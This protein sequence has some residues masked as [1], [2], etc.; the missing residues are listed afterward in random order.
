M[1]YRYLGRT[2]IKVSELG[3][4]C[5]TFEPGMVDEAA[6][7]NIMDRYV[8]AGG[9]FLD[10]ADNYRGVEAV[11]G[12]WAAQKGIR[13]QLVLASKVRY[14]SG[15]K[16]VNDIGLTRKHIYDAIDRTLRNLQTDYIDLYQMH[17]WDP[18]TPI[19]ESLRAFDDLIRA[20]KIRYIG[21]S[22]FT[23]WHI[24][25][26]ISESEK[27]HWSSIVSCQSQYS[28]LSRTAEWE[29]IPVCLEHGI[30]VNAW[31]PLGAGWLT[32]KYQRNE[33]PPAGSR[34]SRIAKNREDWERIIKL[35]ISTQ[36]PHPSRVKNEKEYR[37]ILQE[38]E[39]EHR[40]RIIDAVG[41][42]A[43]AKGKT[44]AQ[45][46][47]A[48]LLARPGLC[49][50]I[51]GSSSVKQLEENLGACQCCL[52]QE[53][54]QWLDQVSDPGRPYPHDFYEKYSL[55]APWR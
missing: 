53:E 30:S 9:N 47:L 44:P 11:V 34:M 12:R 31:S 5:M 17:C 48:W 3:L 50:P 13:Q 41:E 19:D 24:M 15:D 43:N 8:E 1:E 52:T 2:G 32:G 55:H 4:G 45:V 37:E 25:K 35:D 33:M 14:Q 23:G 18:V 28:L 46:A 54:V 40:W 38:H 16:G 39:T 29:I 7:G 21:C 22:N 10:M 51:I 27:N 6:A 26:T 36:I 42:L 20:G 49:S